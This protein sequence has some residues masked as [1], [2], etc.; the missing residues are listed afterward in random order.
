MP[1]IAVQSRSR[2]IGRSNSNGVHRLVEQDEYKFGK[3]PDP[4]LQAGTI[5]WSARDLRD[6]QVRRLWDQGRFEIVQGVL[7]LMPAARF[8]GGKVVVNLQF[9]VRSY[10]AA[11]KVRVACS[12]EVDIE[13]DPIRVPHADGVIV[14]GDDL[15]KFEALRF[16]PPNSTWEDNSLTLPPTIVIE[17][18]SRGHEAHDRVIKRKWYAEFKVPHYWLVDGFARTLEC[19][20]LER[21]EYVVEASGKSDQTLTLPSFPGLKMPLTEV[22]GDPPSSTRRKGRRSR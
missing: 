7:T 8:R 19:L 4:V 9:L 14:V 10:F 5:G 16:D 15:A 22:W 1:S 3:G 18:L 12:T 21:G 6:P 20:R 2:P 17:S 13:V 11:R